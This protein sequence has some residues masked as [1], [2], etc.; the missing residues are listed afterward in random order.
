MRVF[1][2]LL[3]CNAYL[4]PHPGDKY[5]MQQ[6]TLLLGTLNSKPHSMAGFFI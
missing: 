1:L 2:A 6:P 4:E 5:K 3:F